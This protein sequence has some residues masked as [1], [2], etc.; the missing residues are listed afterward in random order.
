VADFGGFRKPGK[1]LRMSSDHAVIKVEGIGKYFSIYDRPVDR[2]KQFFMPKM[3]AFSGHTPKSY[4]HEFWALRDVSFEVGKGQ[5]VGIIGRNGSGKSTLLQIIAGTMTPSY[6]NV[7][8]QGR[9]AALLEL[10]SGFNPEFTGRENVYLNGILLGL[11]TNQIDDKFDY[12][13][14]FADIGDHLDQ[15]VKTYSSGMMCRLAFA[16]QVAVESEILIIDEALAV[17]DARFQLKCF[18]RLEELKASGTTIL[19]VSHATDSVRSFCDYG[20]V[21]ENGRAIYWGEAKA[22][23]VKYMEVLFPEQNQ[24]LSE[25]V[26]ELTALSDLIS[27]DSDIELEANS[28]NKWLTIDSSNMQGQTFGVGGADLSWIKIAGLNGPNLLEGGSQIKIQCQF[29]WNIEF[30]K[31]LIEQEKYDQNITLGVSMADKKG[32]YIFGCNGFDSDLPID[33]LKKNISIVEFQFLMPYLFAEEYFLTVAI[34]LG[35]Q[36]HHIQ[37]RWHDFVY[38]FKNIKGGKNVYGVFAIDYKMKELSTVKEMA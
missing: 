12:I 23:T 13:V 2:L 32:N 28:A 35:S 3:R 10:G 15:P 5:T 31:G 19:F 22:A 7:S 37:L 11:T 24:S 14:S 27:Q 29:I 21:L 33:C 25:E 20:L 36:K 30:I 17:G 9:T 6:G 16:V 38:E 18:R 4:H 26:N 34:A 8:I 1:V